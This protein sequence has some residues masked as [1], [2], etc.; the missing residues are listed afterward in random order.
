MRR[1]WRSS[2]AP[3]GSNGPRGGS[4]NGRSPASTTGTRW[5]STRC[6]PAGSWDRLAD[7]LA[8]LGDLVSLVL[9]ADPFGD[10]EPSRLAETFN[11]GVVPFKRHH[12]VELGP[13]VESLAGAHHR[14]N[15][16]KALPLMEIERIEDPSRSL[17]DWIA[18]YEVLTR[19]HEIHGLGAFSPHSF[20]RQ[21][22]MPGLVAFRAEADG[23]TIGML[24]WIVQGDVAYYHLG[25]YDEAGYLRNASFALFWRAIEWFGG[26]VRWLDLGAGAGLGDGSGGLDRFKAGWATGTRTAYLCR[27]VFRPDRYEAIARSIGTPDAAY[28]PSYRAGEVAPDPKSASRG[29]SP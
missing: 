18:L 21:L 27:H 12:V 13:P 6:L 5:V 4:W 1:R 8:G 11:R 14:R 19:R 24:L 2:A 17:D 23:S 7:D 29:W 20:A 9:V 3:G 16:R 25:A 26:R 22:A 15:A 10:Y 28:F